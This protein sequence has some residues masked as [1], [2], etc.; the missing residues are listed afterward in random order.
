MTVNVAVVAPAGIE[1]ETGK[2]IMLDDADSATDN[3]P[4]G[5]GEDSVTVPAAVAPLVIE[6]GATLN[7]VTDGGA[8]G[9]KTVRVACPVEPL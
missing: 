2:E 9:G 3:P 6:V 8:P 4:E 5:A 1:R 7:D